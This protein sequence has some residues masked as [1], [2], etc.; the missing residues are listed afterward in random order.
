MNAPPE[1]LPLAVP[2]LQLM[3]PAVL[4]D[5]W[6]STAASVLRSHLHARPTL[7]VNTTMQVVHLALA[8]PLMAGLGAW[9]G[10]GLAGYAVALLAARGLGLVLFLQAW[11]TR[12]GGVPAGSDW[13][14][15]RQRALGPVLHIG[16]P[17]AAENVAWRA[18][19][20]FSISVV[21]TMGTQALATHAGV[22]SVD[23]TGSNVFGQWL[24]DHVQQ[25]IRD[26]YTPLRPPPA[27]SSAA[28]VAES[29]VRAEAAPAIARPSPL[30]PGLGAGNAT[31]VPR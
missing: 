8:V 4:L 1:V 2:L 16:L 12:L 22:K 11:R 18:A 3:A 21:G 9:G 19:Y 25:R 24:I 5:A 26:A 30:L 20:V 29:A 6:N 28:P 13:W 31:E 27:A 10:W 23:F 15:W 7:V 17:G 14:Q